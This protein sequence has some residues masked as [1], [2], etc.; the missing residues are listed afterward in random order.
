[1]V[2]VKNANSQTLDLIGVNLAMLSI[3]KKNLKTELAVM[4]PLIN[5]F[6]NTNWKQLTTKE[7]WNEFLTSS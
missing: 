5:L 4:K 1:M 3:F 7:Y 2:C 6:K